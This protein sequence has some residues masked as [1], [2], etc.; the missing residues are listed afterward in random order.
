[1]VKDRRRRL[2]RRV[3][4]ESDRLCACGCGRRTMVAQ[5]T[6]RGKGWVKGEGKRFLK[7]HYG[8]GGGRLV[9]PPT[10]DRFVVEDRG[11]ET[12]CWVWAGRLDHH[13][14]GKMVRGG[15]YLKAHRVSFE[16]RVGPIPAGYDVHHRCEVKECVRPEHLLAL[17]PDEHGKL[18]EEARRAAC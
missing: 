2:E 5:V 1:M 17:T 13:G 16:Q 3:M 10:A 7:G 6:D 11:F 14:Y 18:H 9:S 8:G 12:P 4:A 15:K